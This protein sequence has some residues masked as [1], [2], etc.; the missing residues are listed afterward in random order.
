MRIVY[1]Q[2][3]LMKY[4]ASFFSKFGKNVEFFSFATAL[5]G[6]LR[7]NYSYSYLKALILPV[8]TFLFHDF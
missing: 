7:V 8:S 3:I 1:W 4:H 5:I 6:A 2:T